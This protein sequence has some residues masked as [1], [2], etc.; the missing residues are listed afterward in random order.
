MSIHFP[1]HSNPIL[2]ELH[3]LEVTTTELMVVSRVIEL[4]SLS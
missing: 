4:F 1:V 2:V 3:S